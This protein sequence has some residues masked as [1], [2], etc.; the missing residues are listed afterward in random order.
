MEQ[1][2][3]DNKKVKELFEARSAMNGSNAVL[4]CSEDKATVRQNQYRDYITRKSLLKYLKAKKTD[5]LLDFG[6][7]VGRIAQRVANKVHSVVGVD[8]SS[9][10]IDK[11]KKECQSPNIEYNV[12][13]T[14]YDFGKERFTKIYTC[15]VLQHR[16]DDY[17]AQYVKRF[18]ECLVRKGRVVILEQVKLEKCKSTEYLVQRLE[19]DYKSLFENAGFRLIS[20]K[21]VFRVPSY[22]MDLW[23]K[24]N[25]S[26][27]FLPLLGFIE[28]CTI[29]RNTKYIDY[30]SSVMVFEKN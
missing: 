29:M 23:K 9:G 4:S 16:S 18:N 1:E 27:L 28:K 10:M 14:D 5:N 11:A 22:S 7:G 25:I 3:V 15:W 21:K 13:T 12:L 20:A 17:L 8:V 26:K 30:V 24:Y 6:C 19:S 2:I